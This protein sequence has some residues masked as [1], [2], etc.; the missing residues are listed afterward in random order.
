MSV[1]EAA[2][3]T[4]VSRQTLINVMKAQPND[5][6]TITEQRRNTL[7]KIADGLKIPWEI[8]E[9]AAMIDHGLVKTASAANVAAV[10]D[11]LMGF[12]A[13]D[14]A[15]LQAEISRIQ[16]DLLEGRRTPMGV[17]DGD[18]HGESDT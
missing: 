1:R 2:R 10:V 12:D 4:G 16:R 6:I 9:R 8:M 11:Q 14:L 13:G 7:R 18:D 15:R 17:T 5:V 3:I